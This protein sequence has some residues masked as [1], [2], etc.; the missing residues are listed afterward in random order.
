[1]IRWR[2]RRAEEDLLARSG[3]LFEQLRSVLAEADSIKVAAGLELGAADEEKIESLLDAL[4]S[5]RA[6]LVR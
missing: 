6:Q 3:V 4:A 5:V 1:M 2:R